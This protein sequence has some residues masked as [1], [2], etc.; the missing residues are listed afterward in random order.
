MENLKNKNL[1]DKS[2]NN[3]DPYLQGKQLV[4]ALSGGI[5]SVVLLH[6]LNVHCPNNLRAIHCNHHLSTHCGQWAEFC[7]N[8]CQ[9][10][11]IEYL[12]V[13]IFIKDST[14]I[15]ENARK[16]RY[17]ELSNNLNKDEVLC[18]AHHQ[19]D[20]A[21]T[22]LLQLFRGS[23]VAGL[24]AMPKS[25]PI[26]K[27]THYRPFLTVKKSTIIEYA[28]KNKLS[29][30]GDNSNTD[31]NLRRNFVRLEIIPKLENVYKNLTK[32]LA[33]SAKHQA[34]TLQL[35]Q[36]LALID[37]QK[38]Q[39]INQNNRLNVTN[40]KKLDL[41]RVKNVIRHHLNTLDFLMPSNKIMTQIIGLLFLKTDAQ[42]LVSWSQFEV[43][44]YKNELYFINTQANK[45]KNT[46][47]CPFFEEFKDLP[48]FSIR[49][50]V[51]GQ[52]VKLPGKTHSQSL[53][54][55]LQE[56]SIAPWERNTLKMYYVDNE[57]RA[58][59]RIGKIAQSD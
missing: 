16:R 7:Q 52:R 25:K 29:W 31:T 4:V 3:K 59:E 42:P 30:I 33:R 38:Q 1:K 37:I 50:R 44:R 32:T 19:N 46:D 55:I 53:K 8:L 40:L 5:D 28:Q 15:E 51:E 45:D 24:A 39:L 20:Q 26:G 12:N 35:I 27:G 9:S 23:G 47:F 48:N 21:E 22:L 2:L 18:T 36:D 14:N 54:K 6:Y 58:M 43:R 34:E 41:I 10:L 49:Y 17:R 57:L 11:A 13:D 56:A